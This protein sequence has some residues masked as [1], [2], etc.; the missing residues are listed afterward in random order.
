MMWLRTKVH[1]NEHSW[2]TSILLISLLLLRVA[3]IQVHQAALIYTVS[4]AIIMRSY[5]VYY[6]M[7]ALWHPHCYEPFYLAVMYNW[8]S[9][10]THCHM[11]LH[12]PVAMR[13]LPSLWHA[14]HPNVVGG[15]SLQCSQDGGCTTDSPHLQGPFW[16]GVHLPLLSG[17]LD[18]VT[19]SANEPALV[20]GYKWL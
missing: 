1:V 3:S 8:C 12:H 18:S 2:S 9:C 14:H 20:H 15:A 19:S 13:S 7:Y 4:G 17:V 6:E 11:L 10:L 16:W 5:T